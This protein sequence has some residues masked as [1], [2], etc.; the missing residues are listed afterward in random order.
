MWLFSL[1]IFSR[2]VMCSV[3]QCFISFYSQLT[4]QCIDR[5]Q[6]HLFARRWAFGFFSLWALMNSAS[7]HFLCLC[8]HFCVVICWERVLRVLWNLLLQG[9][10]PWG[11]LGQWEWLSSPAGRPCL[12]SAPGCGGVWG[13][14][15]G[16]L[17]LP[18]EVPRKARVGI[19]H[20]GS[21]SGLIPEGSS[22]RATG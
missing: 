10:W 2:F 4:L 6:I 15:Q 16:T 3:Y 11:W 8:A 13:G 21:H 18:P 7:L 17:M 14:V 19:L 12:L 5:L 1:R 20:Q 22:H 9:P